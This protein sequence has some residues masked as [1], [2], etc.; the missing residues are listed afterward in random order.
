L[1]HCAVLVANA[2]EIF[3]I[4]GSDVGE[5][6]GGENNNEKEKEKEKEI[7]KEKA[8]PSSHTKEGGQEEE[9][10]AKEAALSFFLKGDTFPRLE[11]IIVTLGARG[12]VVV[13]RTDLSHLCASDQFLQPGEC[14]R[15]VGPPSLS[16]FELSIPAPAL[17]PEQVV[18]T[19]GA[20]DCFVGTFLYFLS[21]GKKLEWCLRAAVQLAAESVQRTGTQSSYTG[22][23]GED[24][25]KEECI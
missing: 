23:L 2:T 11:T 7:G 9:M 20:G 15:Q 13:T 16:L 10:S 1:Q 14:A 3:Q 18:D 8:S 4:C 17:S 19:T 5:G 6:A 12:C 21:R 25:W 24:F 22:V